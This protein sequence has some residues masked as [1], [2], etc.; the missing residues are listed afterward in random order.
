MSLNWL[1]YYIIDESSSVV[2]QVSVVLQ[3]LL[4]QTQSVLYKE[5]HLL[6]NIS[7]SGRNLQG[8]NKKLLGHLVS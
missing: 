3:L 8:K 4:I 6:Y 2:V 5:K 7:V 1:L